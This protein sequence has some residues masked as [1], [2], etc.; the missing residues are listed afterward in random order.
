[1]VSRFSVRHLFYALPVVLIALVMACGGSTSTPSAPAASPAAPTAPGSTGTPGAPSGSGTLAVR[2]TDT[3]FADASA[4]VVTFSEVT[5]HT[6]EDAWVK[7]PF[8][9]GGTSRSCDLKRLE[10]AEDVLGV[11][12]LAAAH[13][14]QLRLTVSSAKIYFEDTTGAPTAPACAASFTFTPGTEIGKVVDVPS[15][16]V[17]LVHQFDVK[18]DTTTTI[19]LDFDGD[20]SINQLGNGSYKM[21]PVI[22]VVSVQ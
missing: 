18:T 21:M 13:Y 17:K 2:I 5:A 1:M 7:L 14:T 10:K 15:G 20:K 22:K 4:V 8:A 6:S 9:D 3:P 12:S 11:G 19:L 16:I